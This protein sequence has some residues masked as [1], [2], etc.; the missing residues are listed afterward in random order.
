[1]CVLIYVKQRLGRLHE[2]YTNKAHNPHVVK[3]ELGLRSLVS[4]LLQP[5]PGQKHWCAKCQAPSFERMIL[6]YV[7]T[8]LYISFMPSWSFQFD[9]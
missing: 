4:E 9:E 1:M 7:H 3:I 8:P 2:L 6:K 5:R